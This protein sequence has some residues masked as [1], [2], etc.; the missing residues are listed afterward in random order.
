MSHTVLPFTEG[1][2]RMTIRKV[3]MK[4]LTQYCLLQKV[5]VEWQQKGCNE[6]PHKVLPFTEGWSRMT[7]KKVAMK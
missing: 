4:C 5:V 3:A 7:T 6:V 1:C 2:S